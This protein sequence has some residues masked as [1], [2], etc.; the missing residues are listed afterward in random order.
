MLYLL[1]HYSQFYQHL[2]LGALNKA[3]GLLRLNNIPYADTAGN[4]F[5]RTQNLYVFIQ[6]KQTNRDKLKTNTRAFNKAG[7]KVIY[8]FLINSEYLN[9]PYRF[10]CE[11]A[12]VTIAT[13]G[14]V[15]KDLLKQNYLVKA[16]DNE[17]K[18]QNREKLFEKWVTQYNRNLRPK[19]MKKGYR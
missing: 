16:N 7:L 13:V 1:C 9:K 19:L 15:L 18:F 6:T 3:K 11:K 10:I 5:F 17:Y 2:S 12:K 14:V 4:M 8:Q